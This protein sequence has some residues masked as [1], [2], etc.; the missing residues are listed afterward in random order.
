MKLSTN[1]QILSEGHPLAETM[2]RPGGGMTFLWIL[3]SK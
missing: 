3:G 1:C 2:G